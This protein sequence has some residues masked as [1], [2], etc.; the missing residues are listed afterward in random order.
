[1]AGSG[2]DKQTDGAAGLGVWEW[3]VICS[4]FPP[5]I[6][7]REVLLAGNIPTGFGISSYHRVCSFSAFVRVHRFFFGFCKSSQESGQVMFLL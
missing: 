2:T 4:Y 1:M 6:C 3:G 7:R 5:G